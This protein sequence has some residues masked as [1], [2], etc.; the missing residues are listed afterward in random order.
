MKSTYTRELPSLLPS[1]K[2]KGLH[3]DYAGNGEHGLYGVKKEDID[4]Y[5]FWLKNR[6]ATGIRAEKNKVLAG[7]Y[8]IFFRWNFIGQQ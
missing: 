3:I 4:L 5:R 8:T 6:R 1:E 7:T 2:D